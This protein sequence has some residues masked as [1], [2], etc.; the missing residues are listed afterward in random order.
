VSPIAG[1][2]V[3]AGCPGKRP[4]NFEIVMFFEGAEVPATVEDITVQPGAGAQPS[5]GGTTTSTDP[6]QQGQNGGVTTPPADPAATATPAPTPQGG[7]AQ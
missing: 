3:A 5:S 1:G 4:P 7:A 6:S 2:A